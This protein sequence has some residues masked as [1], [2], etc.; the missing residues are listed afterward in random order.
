MIL[1]H[2]PDSFDMSS[3]RA[4]VPRAPL[5]RGFEERDWFASSRDLAEGL[6]VQ[7]ILE[8]IPAELLPDA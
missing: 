4:A 7:E 6:E 2:H 3:K 8:T 5:P 1:P